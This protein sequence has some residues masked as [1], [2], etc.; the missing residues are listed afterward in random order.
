[1]SVDGTPISAVDVARIEAEEALHDKQR[2]GA[3]KV[4]AAAS[5][6]ADD[7]RMLL[8]ILGLSDATV[9]AA[10]TELAAAHA[11]PAAAAAPKRPR[12]RRVAA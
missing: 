12:K 6:D 1:M 8:S 10:R 9:R 5:T 2:R 7:C 3:A 11:A 4:I